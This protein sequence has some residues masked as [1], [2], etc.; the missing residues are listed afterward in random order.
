MKRLVTLR[1]PL[2]LTLA[3]ALLLIP[4]VRTSATESSAAVVPHTHAQSANGDLGDTMR[5]LWEDHVTWTRLYIVSAIG[6]L[7]DKELTAKRLLQNQVDIGNAIAMFYGQ[8]AGDDVASLLQ[9]HILG[10]ATLIDAAIAGDTAAIESAAAAW[11]V[12]GDEIAEYL[13][14]LNPDNWPVDVLKEQMKMH[15][16][17]T[18]AE[19]QAQLTGDYE[20]SIAHYDQIHLHILGMADLLTQGIT[21]QF[22]V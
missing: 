14:S 4:M 8:K 17:M 21:A 6:D 5:K 10:A 11:Y 19:A 20:A 15:L 9:E 16:D 3:A 13:S 12:N 18:L 22:P 2:L 7:P 1:V